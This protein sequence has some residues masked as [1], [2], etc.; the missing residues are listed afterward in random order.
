LPGR[1]NTDPPVSRARQPPNSGQIDVFDP[2]PTLALADPASGTFLGR[3]LDGDPPGAGGL[4][5]GGRNSLE[6]RLGYK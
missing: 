4:P 6:N 3:E 5:G 1:G 2:R